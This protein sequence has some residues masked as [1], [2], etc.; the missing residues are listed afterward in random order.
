[1]AL[2]VTFKKVDGL[3]LALDVYPPQELGSQ[4]VP[5]V[6][7]YH[8]G[9]LTVGDRSSWFPTWLHARLFTTGIA[10]ISA[11]YR[12]LPPATGHEILED[13]CDALTRRKR[14]LQLDCNA[15]AVA[16]TSSGGLCAYLAAAHGKSRGAVSP[17][18][19]LSMYGMGANFLTSHYLTPKTEPFF[20]GRELLDPDSFAEFLHP[21]AE[22]LP[23]IS[24]SP[25]AYHSNDSPTPG[26]PANPRMQLARL[27]LQMGNFL[28]YYTGQHKPS[29]SAALR[30][31]KGDTHEEDAVPAQHRRLFPQ[32]NFSSSWPPTLICHGECDTAVPVAES[33]YLRDLLH[34]AGVPIDLRIIPGREHSFDY[35]PG[36]ENELSEVFDD[37]VRWL[38]ERLRS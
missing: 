1:M 32:F 10:L 18:A 3:E 29:L 11:D 17:K 13:V 12:L 35:A 27:Y 2:T 19:L 25:L 30:E 23:P 7:Y 33:V 16:G 5:A 6:V 34:E 31:F 15:V 28:D 38:A 21:Q 22:R 24:V 26:Y 9:G 14:R 37:I 36:A 4:P 20:R 8:G